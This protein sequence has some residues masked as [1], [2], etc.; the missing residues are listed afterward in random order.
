MS[1]R[2]AALLAALA[3][4]ALVVACASST[5]PEPAP[6]GFLDDYSQLKPGRGDQAQPD[7]FVC[8]AGS[9]VAL[10]DSERWLRRIT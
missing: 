5:S 3:G 6:S 9:V 2:I 4:T 7:R 1:E 8:V 10:V